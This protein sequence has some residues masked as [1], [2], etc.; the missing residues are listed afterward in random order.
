MNEFATILSTYHCTG[1]ELTTLA[2]KCVSNENEKTMQNI[3][4]ELININ[5]KLYVKKMKYNTCIVKVKETE[6]VVKDRVPR[7]SHIEKYDEKIQRKLPSCPSYTDL[8]R[9]L[10]NELPLPEKTLQASKN[11]IQNSAIIQNDQHKHLILHENLDDIE[12]IPIN[13]SPTSENLRPS[14]SEMLTRQQIPQNQRSSSQSFLKRQPQ[15]QPQSQPQSQPQPQSQIFS[16][17]YSPNGSY[18]QHEPNISQQAFTRVQR[19]QSQNVINRQPQTVSHCQQ[20]PVASSHQTKISPN[21]VPK[22]PSFLPLIPANH[23]LKAVNFSRN[24][25]YDYFKNFMG[26]KLENLDEKAKVKCFRDYERHEQ[27]N[28]S[29]MSEIRSNQLFSNIKQKIS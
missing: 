27:K 2:L 23:Q 22:S 5:R 29:L 8:K 21:K 28:K 20:L 24:E 3:S 7:I 26:D 17:K 18:I 4:K 16:F 1:E 6:Y 13:V 14:R 15:P 25:K 10:P 11:R 19:S 9:P 12:F